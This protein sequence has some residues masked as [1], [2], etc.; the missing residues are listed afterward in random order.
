MGIANHQQYENQNPFSHKTKSPAL[1]ERVTR[2][3]GN[4]S[5]KE[6]TTSPSKTPPCFKGKNRMCFDPKHYGFP[7]AA[8]PFLFR[9][10]SIGIP[11]QG[12]GPNPLL[13]D[14][15][16]PGHPRLSRAAGGEKSKQS[17]RR[18]FPVFKT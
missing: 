2:F 14:I 18:Q 17:E 4:S 12:H 10:Y 5:W 9:H 7:S 3:Y 15:F 6:W 16:P 1:K 13:S 8:R 11:K